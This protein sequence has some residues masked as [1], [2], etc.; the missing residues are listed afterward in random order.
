MTRRNNRVPV[1]LSN[2]EK[3]DYTA[4]AK[5]HNRSLTALMRTLL[6]DAYAK[7]EAG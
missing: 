1:Y 3:R 6:A 2:E 4:L 7:Y 5:A